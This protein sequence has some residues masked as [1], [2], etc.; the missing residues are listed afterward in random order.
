MKKFLALIFSSALILGACGNDD[1]S[2]KNSDTKSES[3]TEKKSDDKKDNKSKE[4]KKSKEEKKSQENGDNKSTQDDESTEEQD[5]QETTTNEQV[6][7]QQPATQEQQ[8]TQQAQQ[9]DDHEPTKAEIYE[10]DKQN[11]PGGT[12]YGLIDPEDVNEPSDSQNEEPDEW[13]KGQEE[14]ANATQSEKEE[15]RKRDAEKYGY[16]YDPSDYEE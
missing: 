4:D 9:S 5:T 14:W 3:K 13:I 16:E 15:I 6:Q 8:Q 2:N 12:D 7:S 10:W 11:I 1:T